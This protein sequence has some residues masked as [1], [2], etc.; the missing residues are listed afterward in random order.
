MQGTAG[1]AYSLFAVPLLLMAGYD[2]SNAVALSLLASL[3]QKLTMV[4][5]LLRSIQWRGVLVPAAFMLLSLPLG[6]RVLSMLGASGSGIAKRVVGGPVRESAGGPAAAVGRDCGDGRAAA[7]RDLHPDLRF[8]LPH[9]SAVCI[10]A[11]N[12][13]GGGGSVRDCG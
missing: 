10:T 11:R 3:I 8:V 5:K 9:R 7:R 1:F 13:H 2:C 12:L 4:F 6:L